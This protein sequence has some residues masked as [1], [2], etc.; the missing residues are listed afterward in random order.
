MADKYTD[1]AALE[2]GERLGAD[3]RIRLTDRASPVVV[4]APHGGYIE[5]G[6]SQIAEAI[7][8]DDLTI[9]CFEGLI[10]GRPHSDLHITSHRFDEPSAISLLAAAETVIAVHG[11]A[12]DGDGKTVWMGGRDLHLRDAIASSL[13][14]SNFPAATSGHRLTGSEITNICN[15]G[16]RRSGVQ[17]E[18]PRT[19][20][21]Q[22]VRERAALRRFTDAVRAVLAISTATTNGA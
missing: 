15:R 1:F 2:L 22:L 11:R 3:Y 5:P 12:D 18:I 7:A 14:A 16:V 20:R 19:L 17:L 4:L 13:V 8:G 21:D 6:S 10:P 9:Y